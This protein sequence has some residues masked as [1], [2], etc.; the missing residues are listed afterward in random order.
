VARRKLDR[1]PVHLGY[2]QSHLETIFGANFANLFLQ[3]EGT[4]SS[5]LVHGYLAF[6]AAERDLDSTPPPRMDRAREGTDYNRTKVSVH[7]VLT[8]HNNWPCLVDFRPDH[9]LK[10]RQIYIVSP[11]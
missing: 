7:F 6:L 2:K 11:Y 8:H 10:I 4:E 5:N 9:R 3:P 1:F